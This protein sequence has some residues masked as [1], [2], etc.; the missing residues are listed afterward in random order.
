M[1]LWA[2]ED[3]V[4]TL[5]TDLH[6]RVVRMDVGSMWEE[7]DPAVTASDSAVDAW[8]VRRKWEPWE[9]SWRLL[10]KHGVQLIGNFFGIHASW[11]QA[12]KRL[13][14]ECVE[15]YIR[16]IGA[17]LAE[18]HRRGIEVRWLETF[19]EM[20][21]DW[22]IHVPPA[23]YNAFIVRL[24]R[25]L[26]RRNLKT[27]ILGPGR[28]H[29]D[30]GDGDAWIEALDRQGVEALAGWSIHG[31]EWHKERRNDPAWVRRWWSEGFGKSLTRKDPQRQKPVFVTEYA[32]YADAF[33]GQTVAQAE[34][35]E[36]PAFAV[37][38]LENSFSFLACGANYVCYWQGCE[39]GWDKGKLGL[40][41]SD[42]TRRPAYEALK[43]LFGSLRPGCQVLR[44]PPQAERDAYAVAF[45]C[46]EE[47]RILVAVVNGTDR[48]VVKE[49]RLHGAKDAQPSGHTA[50]SAGA[51]PAIR[52]DGPTAQVSLPATSAAVICW[53][54]PRVGSKE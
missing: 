36:R 32:S 18:M 37:R 53:D 14:P 13:R 2:G 43:V 8:A 26:D 19:N 47:R 17:S 10:R 27:G 33:A 29:I 48:T 15:P 44:T 3:R 16:R 30:L 28:A 52:A 50:Y 6:V 35:I 49:L 25:E 34:A 51:A 1:Q 45:R 12:D 21:G 23:E 31:W 5:L 20:D 22:N 9:A 11:L 39:P 38:V 54:L 24:G 7:F 41:R 4:A 42:G 46:P 40:L